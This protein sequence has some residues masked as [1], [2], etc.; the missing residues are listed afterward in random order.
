[1]WGSQSLHPRNQTISY[2]V[3]TYSAHTQKDVILHMHRWYGLRNR[4]WKSLSIYWQSVLRDAHTH[5]LSRV[6]FMHGGGH[7]RTKNSVTT[8]LCVYWHQNASIPA[9]YVQYNSHNIPEALT[10]R[11]K[12]TGGVFLHFSHYNSQLYSPYP[13]I[14]S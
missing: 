9:D 8:K 5:Y 7:Y 2:Y 12:P 14:S 11:I 6:N 4:E 13:R 1:M 10:G 3:I